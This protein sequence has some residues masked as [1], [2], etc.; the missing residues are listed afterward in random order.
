MVGAAKRKRPADV[1]TCKWPVL[2][3]ANLI[4]TCHLVLAD[5]DTTDEEVST[6]KPRVFRP[7]VGEF[8]LAQVK[9]K[10]VGVYDTKSRSIKIFTE[11][12]TVVETATPKSEMQELIDEATEVWEKTQN[13]QPIAE[14]VLRALKIEDNTSFV[15]W[16]RTLL[17]ITEIP[18]DEDR[19]Q[20]EAHFEALAS[21]AAN[22]PV[23][24]KTFED[25]AG[26]PQDNWADDDPDIT[27]KWNRLASRVAALVG[28]DFNKKTMCKPSGCLDARLAIQLNYATHVS[29]QVVHGSVYDTSNP[30]IRHL[31]QK[32]PAGG[33]LRLQDTTMLRHDYMPSV[34]WASEYK[35]WDEIRALFDE[36]IKYLNRS[37]EVLVL[38]G[39]SNC[40][41]TLRRVV[42][43]EKHDEVCFYKLKVPGLTLYDKDPRFAVVRDKRT[44]AIKKVIF[45]VFHPMYFLMAP[46]ST[47][48]Y[49]RLAYHD[50]IYNAAFSLANTPVQNETCF[51]AS[52]FRFNHGHPLV[53]S[54]NMEKIT[55]LPLGTATIRRVLQNYIDTYRETGRRRESLLDDLISQLR[56]EAQARFVAKAKK[57]AARKEDDELEKAREAIRRKAKSMATR[58]RLAHLKNSHGIL[59]RKVYDVQKRQ[60]GVERRLI[61]LNALAKTKQIRHILARGDQ[62]TQEDVDAA[63]RYFSVHSVFS[64][65]PME[66]LQEIHKRWIA[67]IA[68]INEEP[69]VFTAK[70]WTFL[71][72]RIVYWSPEK[73]WGLR[74]EGDACEEADT[75]DYEQIHPG[76]SAY[77]CIVNT[78]GLGRK[79]KPSVSAEQI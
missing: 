77:G 69:R 34:P 61:L 18:S 24:K 3:V 16:W 59:P 14:D 50:L 67:L 37:V 22:S 15:S 55:G 53:E 1:D 73:P 28:E 58:D 48:E 65:R 72:R 12:V 30:S 64:T 66:T 44:R 27:A 8:D 62:V 71:R 42:H 57:K 25:C 21:A 11:A 26:A 6:P 68:G 38:V 78:T 9:D 17:A 32:V 19:R 47:I 29:S 7:R 13:A 40:K 41:L 23:V 2:L 4:I 10:P 74:L 54:Q 43:V 63:R 56:P 52:S 75:F 51:L 46:T 45:F 39:A 70:D 60:S 35:H 49:A 79:G 36:F 33:D 20:L 5:G 76:V 31:S